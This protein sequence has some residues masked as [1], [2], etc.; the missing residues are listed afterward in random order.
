MQYVI[1]YIKSV[2]I[3]YL[4]LSDSEGMHNGIERWRISALRIMI[5]TTYSFYSVVAIHSCISAVSVNL[6]WIV[7][8]TLGFYICA[9]IQLRLSNSYYTL[10]AYSL[11]FSI[12]AT[13]VS[14]N[15]IAQNPDLA[16]FGPVL[17]FSL[18]LVAFIL[19]GV[20]AGFACMIF[21]IL[22]FVALLNGFQLNQYLPPHAVLEHANVYIISLIFLFFNI[23]TPLAVARSSLAA[24]RLSQK[25]MGKNNV[26]QKQNDFYKTLFVEA[27]IAKLVVNETGLILEVNMA[28]E[29]LLKCDFQ[30]CT[31]AIFIADLFSEFPSQAGEKIVNRSIEGRMK[32]FKLTRSA[33]F[34]QDN[35]FLTIHDITAKAML[36]KTLAAQTIL[37]RKHK[38]DEAT[39]LPNRL[40]LAEKLSAL[41]PAKQTE[42]SLIAFKINNAQFIEQ[43]YGFQILPLLIKELA[44][45]WR[46]ENKTFSYLGSIGATNLTII[47]ELSILYVR[48]VIASF[49]AQLPKTIVIEEQDVPVDLRVGVSFPDTAK[50]TAENLIKNALYAVNSSKSQINFYQTSCLE[51]FIEHQEINILLNEALST[52]ELRIVYQPKV[53]SDGKIIGLEALLRWHSSII[54]VV[55]PSIFIPIAEKSGLI[56]NITNWLIT[57]ICIQ[58]TKWKKQGLEIVPIA[59]NISG[60]DLDHDVFQKH[61]I[62]SLLEHSIN[63]QLIE[64]E[65]TESEASSNIPNALKTI[66]TLTDWGFPVTL[67]DFGKGYSGLSKLISYPVKSVK[68]D[69]QFVTDIHQDARKSK[70]VEAIIAMCRVLNIDILAE[71]TEKLE[72]VEKLLELG[73]TNFQGFVFSRPLEVSQTELLLEAKNVFAETYKVP[74][75]RKR[76]KGTE[77]QGNSLI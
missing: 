14:I 56:P 60:I 3:N 63:P 69:R 74:E 15:L 39:D 71:G 2:L 17:V 48:S 26:L 61:L 10:S 27:D 51:R 45:H 28:A 64:L 8:I 40:L 16:I 35:F 58:I 66:K 4:M 54:G 68:I 22:P 29:H 73:C 23:C 41:L 46:G 59:L 32:A 21:N 20:R 7:P 6:P 57:N 13:S 65:L 38:F 25:L 55:S 77:S 30:Q 37:N 5:V 31:Q 34:N 76:E 12:V 53:K 47:S 49:I 33:L 11:L 72:E 18:P 62:H 67:D 75:K 1:R 24:R 52:N 70:V 9:A 36:H 50:C 44:K 19:L 42:L 43:K